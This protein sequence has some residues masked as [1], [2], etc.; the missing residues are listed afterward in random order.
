VRWEC[1]FICCHACP[2]VAGLRV[3]RYVHNARA[4]AKG[5]KSRGV[6][7]CFINGDV[8]EHFSACAG[9]ADI[10]RDIQPS[11]HGRSGLGIVPW[12]CVCSISASS[13]GLRQRGT[14]S[15][16]EQALWLYGVNHVSILGS[17][18]SAFSGCRR[19]IGFTQRL[20]GHGTVAPTGVW[21]THPR[22][23]AS[24]EPTS[25]HHQRRTSGDEMGSSPETLKRLA[26]LVFPRRNLLP[27]STESAQ[28]LR[29][30]VRV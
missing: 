5:R 6:N 15:E 28:S 22:T 12:V 3:H 14:V 9:V 7:A 23:R 18:P 4:R 24:P 8:K 2:T 26:V 20:G 1:T 21:H 16:T 10:I 13:S 30:C 29:S 25:H 11:D 27:S 19:G 17:R